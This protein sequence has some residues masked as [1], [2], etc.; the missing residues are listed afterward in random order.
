MKILY[1]TD[2]IYLHGGVEKVLSQKANYF[3]EKEGDQL[4][5]VTHSQQKKKTIYPFS[6]KIKFIDLE[7]NYVTGK[8]YFHPSNLSKTIAH[9]IKLEK[10]IKEINPDVIIQCSVTPDYYFLPY[11]KKNIPKIKEFH[12]TMHFREYN[13]AKQKLFKHL[14]N[15]TN[16]KYNRIVLL[17]ED[18]L[19]Y[20]NCNNSVVI[21]NPTEMDARNCKLEE[22]KIIAAGRISQQKN[23][24]DLVEIFNILKSDFPNWEVHIFGDD[25]LYRKDKIQEQ[26]NTYG[27]GKNIIFKGVTA[28]LKETFL[29]YSIY[30][31]TSNHETFPM[32]LLEALSVGLPIVSYD[33]PTGPNRIVTDGADGFIVPYNN[34]HA[35]S[36]KLKTLMNNVELRK[37]FGLNAKMN[38][39]R[40]E[41]SKVMTLWK[42]LF[43]EIRIERG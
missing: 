4:F 31:M 1:L 33:C 34:Q 11:I 7:I 10:L 12:A 36:A 2:Q 21:P 9:R 14:S 25:Y 26:I 29:D 20:Y 6:E 5:I 22:K 19:K 42:K 18:E 37:K 35:F 38:A 41:I 28:D 15:Y 27:L 39:K 3:A 40:F 17:N 43:E 24:E 23:F 30:A 16:Q 32:V 8:S 13:T